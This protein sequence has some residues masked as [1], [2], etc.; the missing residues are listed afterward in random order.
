MNPGDMAR[1]V[2]GQRVQVIEPKTRV[3]D[4]YAWLVWLPDYSVRIVPESQ[5]R[6]E[7]GEVEAPPELTPAP[8]PV[9]DP[10]P[11]DLGM[12]PAD[13]V[14]RWN[15]KHGAWEDTRAVGD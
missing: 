1:M 6:T 3:G 5:L 15:A 11:P 9:V 7:P 12:D 14:W 2:D 10:R 4:E 8:T 13:N